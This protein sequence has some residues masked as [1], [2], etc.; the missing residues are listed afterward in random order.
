MAPMRE[1]TIFWHPHAP[2]KPAVGAPCNGCGLCC[3][4]EPC[5]LGIWIS[6]R[7]TGRCR[8][9]QWQEHEEAADHSGR[10]VCAM[11]TDPGSFTGWRNPWIVNIIQR[12]ARRW[13]AAGIGCD[14]DM[15]I[16]QPVSEVANPHDY[17]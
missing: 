13:I 15:H 11:L 10:Y 16:T 12:W 3:L 2:P 8:A 6:R 4:A 14:A 7:R 5:P 1:Q 17:L 9:L